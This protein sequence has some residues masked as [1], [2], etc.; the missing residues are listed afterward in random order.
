VRDIQTNDDRMNEVDWNSRTGWLT[1]GLNTAANVGHPSNTRAA[2]QWFGIRLHQISN[3][4]T[5]SHLRNGYIANAHADTI[6]PASTTS[7]SGRGIWVYSLTG[8]NLWPSAAYSTFSTTSL[9]NRILI[10]HPGVGPQDGFTQYC[11]ELGCGAYRPRWGDYSGAVTTGNVSY[12]ATEFIGNTC[13]AAEYLA[14]GGFC[15][16]ERGPNLNWDNSIAG[17]ITP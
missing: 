1:A 11:P 2:I 15:N 17:M 14:T 4:Y 7:N 3:G 8:D 12:W 13:T 16:G 10:S 6:F 9:P 5:V